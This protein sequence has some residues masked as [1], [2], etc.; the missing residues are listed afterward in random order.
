MQEWVESDWWNPPPTLSQALVPFEAKVENAKLA[1]ENAKFAL[2]NAH[3]E[4]EEARDRIS[5]AVLR[6]FETPRPHTDAELAAS[7]AAW[8]KL[9]ELWGGKK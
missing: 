9:D 6:E 1:L 2:E 8:S 4:L 3:R 7:D 5:D